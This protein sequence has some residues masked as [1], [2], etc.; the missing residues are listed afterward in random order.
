MSS[1]RPSGDG[2]G[3]TGAPP[4]ADTEPRRSASKSAAAVIVPVEQTFRPVAIGSPGAA[5]A[6]VR[7]DIPPTHVPNDN[8]I[9]GHNDNDAACP[10][11][12]DRVGDQNPN[13]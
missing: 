2:G 13:F 11:H 10:L 3:I 12:P 9:A 1:I 7:G 8:V 6:Q 5:D 4:F